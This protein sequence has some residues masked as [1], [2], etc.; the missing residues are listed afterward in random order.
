M[1]TI[2]ATTQ[3]QMLNT[4]PV[5]PQAPKAEPK[6]KQES[7]TDSVAVQT[8]KKGSATA[9]VASTLIT[10][11]TEAIKASETVVHLSQV[12]QARAALQAGGIGGR[13]VATA[14]VGTAALAKGTQ[15]VAK[16]ANGV[17]SVPVIGRLAQPQVA[18]TI[19]N[20]VMPSLNALG[21]GLSIYDN[22]RRYNKATLQGN[23]TAQI[24]SGVQ[25]GLNGLSGVTGFLKG[26]G[27]MISAVA[28]LS[29][30]ALE[31]VTQLTGLGKVK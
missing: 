10:L 24:V 22:V 18:N 1:P 7:D 4:C 14:A 16:L 3:I 19:A 25:I 5:K 27:Q 13:A 30:L 2:Q 15:V 29:S 21:S 31:G 23:Q 20:K 28:G 17:M 8:V 12:M 9:N 6:P 11:P 26:K